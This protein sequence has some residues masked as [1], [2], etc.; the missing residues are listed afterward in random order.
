MSPRAVVNHLQDDEQRKHSHQF[1]HDDA[2]V[3]GEAVIG[4][5]VVL[6]GIDHTDLNMVVR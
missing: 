5:S 3:V 6:E 1:T 4:V 2:L